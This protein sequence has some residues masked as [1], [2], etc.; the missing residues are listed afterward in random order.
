MAGVKVGRVHLCRVAG[1]TVQRSYHCLFSIL[2]VDTSMAINC[3]KVVMILFRFGQNNIYQT[4]FLFFCIVQF[5][6]MCLY[7]CITVVFYF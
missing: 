7:F 2:P 5:F 6:S 1:N 3:M 4:S